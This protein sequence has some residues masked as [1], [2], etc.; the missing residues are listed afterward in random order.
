MVLRI[1]LLDQ[2]LAWVVVLVTRQETLHQLYQAA[3]EITQAAVIPLLVVVMKILQMVEQ[4][5]LVAVEE[6]SH[7]VMARSL[8]VVALFLKI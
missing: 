1:Q 2:G 7:Q 6:T 8:L 5:P 4:Q 3:Q